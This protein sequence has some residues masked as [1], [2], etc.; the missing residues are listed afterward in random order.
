MGCTWGVSRRKALGLA[1]GG[2]VLA[3]MAGGCGSTASK[4]ASSPSAVSVV[5]TSPTDGSV[6]AADHVTIRGTVDPADAVVQ[7]QGQPAAVGNGVFTGTAALHGGKTTIDVIGSASGAAPGST[8]ISVIRQAARTP[9]RPST[10]TTV[11]TTGEQAQPPSDSGGR[12]F[13]APSG[14]VTCAIQGDGAKCSVASIGT[15]FVLPSDG[16]TAY[17]TPGLTISRGSGSEA[18]FGT[19]QSSGTVACTIPPSNAPAGI[20]CRNSVTGHGF[21]AS[22]VRA[23]QKFY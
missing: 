7:I 2:A 8:H 4:T 20:S 14:N 22:R 17:E 1:C 13:F 3:G 10:V 18:P 12:T 9:T 11:V 5:V 6:I 21:E 15:T 16:G 19:E 23:R